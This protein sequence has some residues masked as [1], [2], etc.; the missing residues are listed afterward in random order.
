ME[1]RTFDDA[2]DWLQKY[3]QCAISAAA[4]EQYFTSLEAIDDMEFSHA[5]NLWC[6]RSKPLASWFPTPDALKLCVQELRDQA[7]QIQKRQTPGQTQFLKRQRGRGE[8][9]K[10]AVDTIL[11]MLNHGFKPEA[12]AEMEKKHPGL[13]WQQSGEDLKTWKAGM[14][15]YPERSPERQRFVIRQSH[16]GASNPQAK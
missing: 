3:H 6:G 5:I 4:K 15:Q 12:F 14:A 8:Y 9:Q 10:D 1:R 2:L 11:D 16:N 13:G 7:W